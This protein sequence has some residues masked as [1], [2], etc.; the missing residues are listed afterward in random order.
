MQPKAITF[1]TDAKL[2]AAIKGLNRLAIRH[3]A[4]PRQSYSDSGPLRSCQT[5]QAASVA[6]AHP[7]L[8]AGAGSSATSAARSRG[9]PKLEE[10]F[11]LPRGRASQIRSQQQ[12]QRGWKLYS[13]HALEVECFGKCKASAPYELMAWTTSALS[14]NLKP[15]EEKERS[16]IS[17]FA[18]L[19][20]AQSCLTEQIEKYDRQLLAVTKGD[21]T[22]W[23]RMNVPGIG[24]LTALPYVATIDDHSL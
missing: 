2:L 8:Q 19:C 6:I 9:Q 13:F 24:S 15:P 18:P 17:Y 3:G 21:Q 20:L 12:R 5:V 14:G 16:H 22:V 23:R 7:A 4:K 10:V 1:P 11:A